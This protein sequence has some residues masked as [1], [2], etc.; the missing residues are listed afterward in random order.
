MRRIL[1][2]IFLICFGLSAQSQNSVPVDYQNALNQLQAKNYVAAIPV[3]QKY[4]DASSYGQL[5]DYSAYHLAEAQLG[6][7]AYSKAI[8]ILQPFASKSW[9]NQNE[10][11]YLL[12]LAY[13]G[14]DQNLEALRL[15]KEI[16]D[17]EILKKAEN[18]SFENLKAATPSFLVSN[19]DEF[20]ENG[21]YR[22]ALRVVLS[23]STVLSATERA[24]FFELNAQ[25]AN[26]PLARDLILDI[27]VMLPFTGNGSSEIATDG[28]VYELYEGIDL[29]VEALKA[30]GVKINVRTFD[31]KRDL[32][33]VQQILND[34]V[35]S[36]SDII[37][38]PIYPDEVELVSAFAESKQIPMV[39]PLSNLA[40]RFEN[41]KF[42]YLF[43]PSVEYLAEGIVS[44][45]KKQNW[46]D[47][48][49]IGS[50]GSSRDV[51]L[52]EILSQRLPEEGFKIVRNE[53]VTPNNIRDFLQG[54]GIRSSLD[55]VAV[56]AN[57]VILLTDNPN[58]SQ[59]AFFLMESVTS[60]VPILVM[61]SWLGFNFTNFEMLEF[62]NFYFIG[63]N[64]VNF[65]GE[66]M[67]NFR[68][69]FYERYSIYPSVN[70]STGRELV[71]WVA[72]NLSDSKGFDFRKNLDQAAFQNG[73]LSWG[74]NFQNSNSNQYVPVFKLEM[75]ELKP[76]N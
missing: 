57:Q 29:G 11:K 61:D 64:S 59:P 45:L 24:A 73:R 7:Q 30:Q 66:A 26:D 72:A 28:F 47:S 32:N 4:L 35:L 54:I 62:P 18:A 2:L 58:I 49:A 52:A 34:P 10:S 37:L 38:G 36:R 76:L 53:R 55:S 67:Q 19:L 63:N 6:L 20:K 8:P 70:A 60:T 69:G 68:N 56:D 1:V 15:I 75:G 50:G 40:D 71:Y 48:V 74:F 12:S 51:R 5:A 27:A 42:T 22:G 23:S 9:K 65:M 33:Q 41:R 31:T 43:R 3:F 13:F 21:G 17:E 44:S 39:H 46:G 25:N 16:K 14:N